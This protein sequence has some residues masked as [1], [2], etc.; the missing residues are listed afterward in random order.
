MLNRETLSVRQ[1]IFLHIV[2]VMQDNGGRI[3]S[4]MLTQKGI[5]EAL[6][7]PRGHV[8]IEIERAQSRGLLES[9]LAR[10]RGA[11]RAVKVYGLS[12]SGIKETEEL[13]ERLRREDRLSAVLINPASHD[14]YT[15]LEELEEK[16][17]IALCAMALSKTPLRADCFPA[18]QRMPY[19]V[20]EDGSLT[21]S[22]VAREAVGRLLNDPERKRRA[23]SLLADYHLMTGEYGERLR[24]LLMAGRHREAVKLVSM[25]RDELEVLN[26]EYMIPMLEDLKS[27]GGF[28]G[29]LLA[30]FYFE[31]GRLQEALVEVQHAKDTESMLLASLI[32]LSGG[33]IE[34]PFAEVR[35]AREKSLMH[36]CKAELYMIRG[37]TGNA[38][39][40][41]RQARNAA[42]SVNDIQEL[43]MIY[44]RLSELERMVGDDMEASRLRLK[45][46]L[47]QGGR[48]DQRQLSE[49]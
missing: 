14:P 5:S 41:L 8:A 27:A 9:R 6:N 21:L 30:R 26:H 46:T 23:C 43:R 11:K 12:A 25:H 38:L 1:R 24:N 29:I 16:D 19:V 18:G 3:E 36:R 22:Y 17:K 7:I 15:V 49:S 32:R 37:E 20:R 45:L 39:T 42:S 47:L 34:E 4:H 2:K 40:E 10:F 28:G 48:S 31:S 13:I 33:M 44:K 35:T